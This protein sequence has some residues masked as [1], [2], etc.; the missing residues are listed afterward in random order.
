MILAVNRVAQQKRHEEWSV[1]VYI[2][3]TDDQFCCVFGKTEGECLQ[4]ANDLVYAYNTSA[5]T[6]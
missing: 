1:I 4:R 5:I 3:N 6:S 2:I